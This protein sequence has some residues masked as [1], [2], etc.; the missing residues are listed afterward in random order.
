MIQKRK[1]CSLLVMGSLVVALTN[2]G[3]G[4]STSVVPAPIDNGD[5]GGNASGGGAGGGGVDEAVS[6]AADV[7]PIF[8]TACAGCH[9]P[10]GNA[11]LAGIPTFLRDGE[12]YDMLVNVASVQDDELVLVVPGDSA[13]SL[14]Y[15]KVASNSP[16][17]GS[18]M[19]RFAPALSED[20]IKLIQDWIDQ[21]A[22]NN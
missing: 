21:G 22:E 8:T 13:A 20:E 11:D 3:T 16:P 15:Q 19:P 10:G 14:L 9:S 5:G 6:F 18:R 17:V 1:C 2:L 7:Q 4:C 12:S